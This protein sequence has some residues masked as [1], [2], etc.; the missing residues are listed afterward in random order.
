MN[1]AGYSIDA[2][3]ILRSSGIIVLMLVLSII[4]VAVAIESSCIF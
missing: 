2:I 3:Q 4:V 1:N